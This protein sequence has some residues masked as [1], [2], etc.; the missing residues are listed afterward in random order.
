MK[1]QR[2][3]AKL[4]PLCSYPEYRD[5][6]VSYIGKFP[7]HWTLQKING[8]D[9]SGLNTVLL[10]YFRAGVQVLNL[11]DMYVVV[12][13]HEEQKMIIHFLNQKM[14]SYAKVLSK[15]H[16][17]VTA[18]KLQEYL[19]AIIKDVVTGKVDVRRAVKMWV[20]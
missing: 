11:E 2:L 5:S 20:T 15:I 18:T 12:P 14:E 9:L 1:I 17:P 3:L 16:N 13:P 7:A 10:T 8:K 6:G 4:E 19:R